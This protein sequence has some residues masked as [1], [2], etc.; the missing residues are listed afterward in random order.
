[1]AASVPHFHL[2]PFF[3]LQ[4]VAATRAEQLVLWRRCVLEHCR[5]TRRVSLPVGAAAAG[6]PFANDQI[7]RR[8]DEQARLTVAAALVAAGEAQ[9]VAKAGDPLL[10]V[11]WRPIKHWADELSQHLRAGGASG[12]F[13]MAELKSA[14]ADGPLRGSELFGLGSNLVRAAVAELVRTG[15]A[16]TFGAKPV[17]G[18]D[19]EVGVKLL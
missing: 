11:W 10:L 14:D 9:W 13:T 5:D 6:P 19:D 17:G 16:A 18:D 15:R 8:L 12:V 2:P 1:M 4:P 7:D 3:T